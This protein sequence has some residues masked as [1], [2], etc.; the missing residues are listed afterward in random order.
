MFLL[1]TKTRLKIKLSK[2][3]I[4]KYIGKSGRKKS[5]FQ[6]CIL[7]KIYFAGEELK[8][9]FWAMMAHCSFSET[10]CSPFSLHLELPGQTGSVSGR[11]CLPKSYTGVRQRSEEVLSPCPVSWRLSPLCHTQCRSSRAQAVQLQGAVTGMW[12]AGLWSCLSLALLLSGVSGCVMRL[13]LVCSCLQ[14]HRWYLFT[15]SH[16][17]VQPAQVSLPKLDC[18]HNYSQ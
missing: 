2:T 8:W 14:R 3:G 18:D 10:W 5:Y 1:D 9:Q 13:Q 12:R 11:H 16:L 15:C 7:C 4:K 17:C 6:K